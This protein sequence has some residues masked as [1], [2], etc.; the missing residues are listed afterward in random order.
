LTPR[1][2]TVSSRLNASADEVWAAVSTMRGV[3][4]E[5]RPLVRM[6]HP[7]GLTSLDSAVVPIGERAF[8]SWILLFGFLPI[9]YD[10]LT[11]VALDPGRGFHERSAMLTQR[12]WEHERRLEPAENGC[13]IID[14]VSFEPRAP[15]IGVLLRPLFRAVFAHRHRRLRRRF[16]GGALT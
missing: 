2:F 7:P 12:R 16:G 9:D 5:L 14:I 13:A 15:G 11:F 8:R 6:T 3:N 10:D 1:G 4:F